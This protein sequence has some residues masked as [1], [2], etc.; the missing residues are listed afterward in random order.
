MSL[1]WREQL[2]V[3]N[4]QIDSDHKY[5]IEIINQVTHSLKTIDQGK[6]SVSVDNLSRFLE[7]HCSRE[8]KIASAVGYE[9]ISQLYESH[10]A[11]LVE[12]NK[13]KLEIGKVDMA[14]STEHIR[15][16]LGELFSHIIK[17]D[18]LM[19][20]TLKKYSPSFVPR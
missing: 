5:L 17:E 9:Q 12:L 1:V 16:F 20:P 2:G 14:T 3:G 13:I 7:V 18:L 19:K 4:E 6:L 10:V 8:E 15:V 11:L